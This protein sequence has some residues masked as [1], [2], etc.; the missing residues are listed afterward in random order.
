MAPVA[1]EGKLKDAARGLLVGQ[2]IGARNPR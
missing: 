1:T 2:A